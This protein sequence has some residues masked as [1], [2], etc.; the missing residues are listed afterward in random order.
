MFNHTSV[1]ENDYSP[2]EASPR[3]PWGPIQ[4]EVIYNNDV[5]Q[6]TTAGHGGIRVSGKASRK[7]PKALRKTWYEEDCEAWI[8]FYYLYDEFHALYQ[9]YLTHGK[10]MPFCGS[11]GAFVRFSKDEMREHMMQYFA[12]EVDYAEGRRR[13]RTY[14]DSESDYKH[15]NNTYERLLQA[16]AAKAKSAKIA[17]GAVIKFEQPLTFQVNGREIELDT[18]RVVKPTPRTTRFIPLDKSANFVAQITRWQAR[19]FEVVNQ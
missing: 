4:H 5:K 17:E 10:R 16:K 13:G 18:F 19:A 14:F 8:A 9:Q 3:S 12:A 11:L 2:Y 1:I 7:I 15:Y 6:V